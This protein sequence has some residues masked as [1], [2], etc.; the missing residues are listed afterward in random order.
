MDIKEI[1]K[2]SL[3]KSLEYFVDTA[4][5]QLEQ[6]S[7]A[8]LEEILS[9]NEDTIDTAM[10]MLEQIGARDSF[11]KDLKSVDEIWHYAMIVASVLNGVYE[12]ESEQ[13]EKFSMGWQVTKDNM[14]MLVAN[15][16]A[17]NGIFKFTSVNLNEE[18]EEFYEKIASLEGFEGGIFKV[19]KFKKEIT[20]YS[21][22]L[23]VACVKDTLNIQILRDELC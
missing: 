6:Q 19:K 15:E 2:T 13:L 17:K 23:Y 4:L 7:S 9:R 18:C 20:G 10:A 16:I 1:L 22:Q 12:G 3:G 11:K 5:G 21:K 14:D 8:E